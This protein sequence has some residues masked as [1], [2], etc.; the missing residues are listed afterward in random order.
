VTATEAA[1][2]ANVGVTRL[3]KE[4]AHLV[5]GRT[6]WT[7][8]IQLPGMLH[9]VLVRSPMAH[10]R[11]S[12]VDVS[13]ALEQPGVVAAYTGAD[14]VDHWSGGLPC[15]WPVTEDMRTP[16]HLPLAT[17]EVRYVGDAVAVVVAQTRAQAVDAAEF[18]DGPT[19]R[20]RS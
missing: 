2:T 5:T 18:V 14:L 16:V 12:G 17:D 11:V 3:R 7:D 4:D 19:T 20:C 1:P 13:A 6:R 15:A 8:N 10:A 9:L